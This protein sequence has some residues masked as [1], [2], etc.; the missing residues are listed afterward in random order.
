M[1]KV[2]AIIVHGIGKTTLGYAQPFIKELKRRFKAYIQAMLKT[3]DD[4]ADGLEIKE[5]VWD[6]ILAGN[7]DKLIE[8][9]KKGFYA[10]KPKGLRAF[11]KK[12]FFFVPN[13]VFKLRTNFAAESISDII[14]YKNQEAYQ[15]I[16]QRLFDEIDSL[17]KTDEKQPLSIIAHSLGTVISSDFIYDRE[18]KCG[19]LHENFFLSNLFT[20]GS[21]I[22]LFALQYGIELFKNPIHVEDENGHWINIFDIDDPIAYPLKNLNEAYDKAVHADK[23]VNTG[24]FSVSHTRYFKDREVQDIIAKKLAIDWIRINK[25]INEKEISHLI[26]S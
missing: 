14:G 17:A 4:Y 11:F 7:Q 19:A 13:I 2:F 22:A 9:L 18:K 26:D 8:I 16:H 23:E 15:K 6:D 5:I 3:K 20:L 1:K 10:H 24:G 21:P 12:M 25:K